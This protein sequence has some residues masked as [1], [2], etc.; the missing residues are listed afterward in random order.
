MTEPTL[1]TLT[2]RL[3][4]AKKLSYMSDRRGGHMLRVPQLA[5]VVVSAALVSAGCNAV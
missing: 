5:I 1:T 4:R 3:D 2:Q